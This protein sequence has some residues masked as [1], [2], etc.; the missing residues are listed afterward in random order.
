MAE[1]FSGLDTFPKLLLHHARVRAERPAIREKDLG[2]WQTWSWHRF[3]DEVRALACGLA[4]HGFKRGD[5]LALVG[6]NRPRI[7]AAMCAAQCLGG[8]PVP[9]YQDAVAAEMAFPIQQRRHHARAGGR[10]GAGRQAAGDPAAMPGAGAHLLRR[11]ARPAQLRAA[12]AHELR[13]AGRARPRILPPRPGIPRDRDRQGRRV[14]HRGDVLHLRH[15]RQPEGRGA[16]ACCADRPGARR[17]ADG[18]A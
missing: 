6:A 18:R 13:Q 8:I 11:A 1:D 9:L 7:Y 10:P 5:H 16:H 12:A 4:A 17:R 14:R 2:I 3:A 15:H